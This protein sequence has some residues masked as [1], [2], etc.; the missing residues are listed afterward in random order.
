MLLQDV[1]R[2]QSILHAPAPHPS[3]IADGATRAYCFSHWRLMAAGSMMLLQDVCRRQSVLHAPSP[4]RTRAYCFMLPMVLPVLL[5]FG[6][7]ASLIVASSPLTLSPEL[8]FFF[9]SFKRWTA[10]AQI[11]TTTNLAPARPPGQHHTSPAKLSRPP[12]LPPT[13]RTSVAIAISAPSAAFLPMKLRRSFPI[14]PPRPR[15][16][17]SLLRLARSLVL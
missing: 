7:A 14:P 17:V 11:T 4:R 10:A 3:P 12:A 8:V 9:V 1:C 2:Q 15:L 16:A 5:S 13:F 6:I